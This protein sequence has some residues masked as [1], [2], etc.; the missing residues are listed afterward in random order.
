MEVRILG[1]VRPDCSYAWTV[2]KIP[3]LPLSGV[4]TAHFIS[5]AASVEHVRGR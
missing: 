3:M 2:W 4:W 5:S 1:Q